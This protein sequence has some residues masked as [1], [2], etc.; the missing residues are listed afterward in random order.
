[1]FHAVKED[2]LRYVK[3]EDVES[4]R[5]FFDLLFFNECLWVVLSYRFGRWVRTDLHVPVVKTIAKVLSKLLHKCLGLLTGIQINFES[6]IGP[7]LYIGHSGYL[8]INANLVLGRNCN[9]GCGVIIGE[10]GRGEMKGSPVIG[11]S[12]FIGVGAKVLGK[13][14]IGD[15]AAI[16]ANAVVVKD[17]PS[18]AVVAGVPARIISYAGSKDFIR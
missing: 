2:F 18:N 10:A 4:I 13:I 12:V 5:S 11:D 17:V 15:N 7:G 8:V 16:G 14:R 3:T 1:M 6:N 9:I